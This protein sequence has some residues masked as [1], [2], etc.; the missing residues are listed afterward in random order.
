MRRNIS[1]TCSTCL[2]AL[3]LT[4]LPMASAFAASFS[5]TSSTNLITSGGTIEVDVKAQSVTDLAAYLFDLTY[6]PTKF[7]F[8][9]GSASEGTFLTTA[10]TTY[11]DGGDP[12]SPGLL[13][14]VYDSLFGPGPGVSGDGLLVSFEFRA[15]DTGVAEFSLDPVSVTV[16]DSSGNIIEVGLQSADVT[17]PEPATLCLLGLGLAGLASTR[18]RKM[19]MPS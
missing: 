11:F 5:V 7:Q 16:L 12:S 1:K 18:K 2:L 9:S 10:G 15:L 14:Y 17:V 13:Q 19:L 3:G 6:D 4:L 8:V